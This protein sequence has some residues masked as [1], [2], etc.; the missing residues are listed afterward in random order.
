MT[1]IHKMSIRLK[2]SS[3]SRSVKDSLTRKLDFFFLEIKVGGATI[4]LKR[5]VGTFNI[6]SI[7]V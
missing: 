7:S 2:K 6:S 4:Y 1:T 5:I 3:N